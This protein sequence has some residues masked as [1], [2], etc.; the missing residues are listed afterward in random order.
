MKIIST[1]INVCEVLVEK[2]HGNE[3]ASKNTRCVWDDNVTTGHEMESG[4]C[5]QLTQHVTK[6]SSLD[7]EPS[8]SINSEWLATMWA[9]VRIRVQR[10]II[11]TDHQR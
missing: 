1:A 5:I 11:S 9:Q 7:N 2:Y 6:G 4:K 10:Y 8:V 3:D